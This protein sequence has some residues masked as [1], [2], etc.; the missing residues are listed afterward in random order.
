MGRIVLF[1][2]EGRRP[3]NRA[4]A[5]VTIGLE[6]DSHG[7]LLTPPARDWIVQSIMSSPDP[8]P[9]QRPRPTVFL[10]YATED[11]AAAQLIRDVLPTYGLE[12][13][14]DES[15]LIG[16]D[17]W[18]QK[19]RRQIRE[20]D[21]FMPVISAQTEARHEGYFR[22]EWRFAVERTLDMADDHVFLLPVV[23]D[24]VSGAQARVPD[25]FLTVQWSRLP[26]GQPTP[27]FAALC[28]RLASGTTVT[29]PS[30]AKAPDAPAASARVRP[31]REFPEFPREEPGQRVRF[32]AEVIG[33]AF[34]SA[35]RAFS[36]LPKWVRVL[37]Y[38]WLAVVL[39]ARGCTPSGHRAASL[40]PAQ[41]NKLK[42]I[43]E[44]DH[45]SSNSADLVS[46]AAQIAREA[47]STDA[48]NAGP[49]P[50]PLLAIPFSAPAGDATARKLADST[51]AQLYGRIAL[52]RQGRVSLTEQPLSSL[53]LS[54]AVRA[55]R[56]HHSTYVI[57]GIVDDSSGTPSLT[58]EIAAVAASSVLWR[59]SYAI[60][61][62][63]ASEIA[64]EV[65]S[66]IPKL[67]G[68]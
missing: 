12:V 19:I 33:W 5:P 16:G 65:N 25:R 68:D 47:K 10:S 4:P 3:T 59:K 39:L 63:D 6:A 57:Y 64:A 49:D 43:A 15:G 58:V 51:F 55:G 13:W 67:Q 28:R 22:R 31:R 53:D 21:Y 18:D 34:Q 35:W 52:T 17:A 60:T 36:R 38:V 50:A 37:A 56:T 24:E 9:P 26:G 20:C 42:E 1:C 54:T 23:I 14:L 48:E 44:S 62:A 7:P 8:T 29:L 46:L 2:R 66:A 41:A 11:R 32:W 27:A 30:P 61:D 40:S 45:A